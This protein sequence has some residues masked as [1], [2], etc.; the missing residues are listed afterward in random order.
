M[1]E[2]LK[3]RQYGNHEWISIADEKND[4]L[5]NR[6]V[7]W[8]KKSEVVKRSAVTKQF[9]STDVMRTRWRALNTEC[10]KRGY[11]GLAWEDYKGLWEAAGEVSVL[12]DVSIAAHKLQKKFYSK[13]FRCMLVRIDERRERGFRRGN[14][15]VVLVEGGWR[16]H[17]KMML[18]EYLE[19]L[20]FLDED[21]NIVSVGRDSELNDEIIE[22]LLNYNLMSAGDK[23]KRYI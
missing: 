10:R 2:T 15:A 6:K 21:G 3:T 19:V 5:E 9:Y 7:V 18:P 11:D 8:K 16:N 12:G 4:P 20:S 23:G 22:E 1:S 17:K 14:V 13:E